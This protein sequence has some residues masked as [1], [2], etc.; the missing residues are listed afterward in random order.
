MPPAGGLGIGIDRLVMLLTDSASIR[1]VI[2]FPLLNVLVDQMA[3]E[4]LK[5]S[6]FGAA[7]MSGLGIAI[8][9]LLVLQG[10]IHSGLLFAN[11][12]ADWLMAPRHFG[13]LLSHTL[14]GN[15]PLDGISVYWADAPVPHWHYVTYGF[16]ELYAKESSDADASG[17]G[18]E[19]TFRLAAEAG[20]DGSGAPPTRRVG[21]ASLASAGQSASSCCSSR[22]RRS[23][24]ASGTVGASST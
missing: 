8:G 15:D 10:K 12:D 24:S 16:S 17:Y 23:Y 2:L 21:E 9:A 7:S 19:L 3:P 11:M 1:D 6:Y 13:T 20:E 5:G 14:G 22:N 18:F 4:H